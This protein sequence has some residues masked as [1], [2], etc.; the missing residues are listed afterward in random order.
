MVGFLAK[1]PYWLS[2]PPR[3]WRWRL[4]RS[5]NR[6][7]RASNHL[8]GDL[9]QMAILLRN[10]CSRDLSIFSNLRSHESREVAYLRRFSQTH[11]HEMSAT[12]LAE[13]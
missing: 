2:R 6:D 7:K 4:I 10:P 12:Q 11:A 8:A 9:L 1:L 3:R 13:Q 5:E